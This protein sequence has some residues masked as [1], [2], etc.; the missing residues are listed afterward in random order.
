MILDRY[1]PTSAIAVNQIL[2]FCSRTE[3]TTKI[4]FDII[5]H[6]RLIQQHLCQVL[7]FYKLKI[8]A[9]HVFY[10]VNYPP[11][12]PRNQDHVQSLIFSAKCEVKFL[13]FSDVHQNTHF[14]KNNDCVIDIFES[15]RFD[16]RKSKSQ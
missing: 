9:C 13:W 16:T 10:R 5:L 6:K 4:G 15:S 11:I 8:I 7:L 14:S 1:I 2:H 3:V 12:Q